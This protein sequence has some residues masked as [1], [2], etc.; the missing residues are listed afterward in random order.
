MTALKTP[1]NSMVE[2]ASPIAD[3]VAQAR[4]QNLRGVAAMLIGVIFF[5]IL[6]VLV[7]LLGETYPITQIAFF[8]NLFALFPVLLVVSAA[9]WR[10]TLQTRYLGAHV[11][12]TLLG[13]GTMLLIFWSY[14]LL[15]LADATALWFSGPLFLTALSV[16]LL[17]ERVGVHRW[18]AVIVG[19]SGVLIMVR[20]SG[21]MLNLGVFVALGA[22]FG[23]AL[24]MV[25]V[26]R[27]SRTERPETIFFY[28]TVFS[29][30][31]SACLLPFEWVTPD[32][33]GLLMLAGAGIVG[34][35]GQIFL[36]AAYSL[37]TPSLVGPF[38]YSSLLWATLFGFLIWGDLPSQTVLAG[39]LVVVASGLYIL[40]R[41]TI[42][43][44]RPAGKTVRPPPDPGV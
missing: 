14:D 1:E 30:L 44:V 18:G 6:N 41:E 38:N 37:A 12:R 35:T 33:Q 40:H 43:R 11:S 36:T 19:F 31:F 23:Y 8:R 24:A 22:A 42:R 17:G 5:S 29:T 28:F 15:P 34:G 21:E 3:P 32:W 26:R 13:F 4:R 2:S 39:A 20:P 10:Q 25:L 9:G 16:P 7:K 27:L